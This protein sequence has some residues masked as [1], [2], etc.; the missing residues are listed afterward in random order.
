MTSTQAASSN[1][2]HTSPVSISPV[3]AGSESPGAVVP[4]TA[5]RGRC[6][7]PVSWSVAVSVGSAPPHTCSVVSA[8]A[9]SQPLI[10]SS[11][12]EQTLSYGHWTQSE[13]FKIRST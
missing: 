6:A 2:T 3:P 9:F 12:T 7:G 4:R 1:D 13:W 8:A 10:V 11:T 5:D